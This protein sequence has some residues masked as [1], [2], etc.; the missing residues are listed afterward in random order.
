MRIVHWF[1]RDLRMSDNTAL[2]AAAKASAGDVVP[3]FVLDDELLKGKHVAP[4]RVAFMLD[5]LRELDASLR[6]AGSQLIV[7]R[8]VPETEILK[9]AQEAGADAVYFNR[10]YTP[11]A[12]ARG[13]RVTDALQA[14]GIRVES[15]RDLVIFE[16]DELLT[17]AGQPYTVFTPYKRAWLSRI[18]EQRLE[19]GDWRF[20][21]VTDQSLFS[22]LQSL[23]IPTSN[24]LGFTLTQRVPKGGERVAMDIL[25]QF[26]A[27]GALEAYSTQRDFP[28]IG[29]GT[30]HL[31]PYLRFGAISPRQCLKVA[32][33][34]LPYAFPQKKSFSPASS[35]DKKHGADA[36]ISELIW[37]DFY[38]QILFNFPHV[39]R[40]HFNRAYANLRYG[41]GDRHLDETL[42]EAWKAGQTGYPIVDAAMRQMNSVAWM[43]NRCRMIVASFLT[44]DLLQDWRV[45]ERHFMSILVDGDPA[46]NNGGWQWAAST[47]TDAQPY[48]R[49]FNPRLQSER[50]D[51]NG[52][53]IR[54]W[55]P[56]LKNLPNEYIHAPAEMPPLVQE[57]AG[58]IIGQH[59]PEP[60][61]NHAVQKDEAIRRFQAAKS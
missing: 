45:G 50:Y 52:E 31:S 36:W 32:V 58:C 8:G 20:A 30:S 49:V 3:L 59:Y 25:M 42:I 43:H 11:A 40:D 34:A 6:E 2:M 19:N 51:P 22:N 33:K 14:N 37:R 28:A 5:C 7:R 54:Q 35:D 39:K 56:E 12:R 53:Y 23:P 9:L 60:I 55:V 21:P 61:V 16:E 13:E 57:Q 46:A 4:A 47:G 10:D 27:S 38:Q 44:K 18:G 15:F 29:N 1:R 48:F 24:E 26:K 17:G 41:T